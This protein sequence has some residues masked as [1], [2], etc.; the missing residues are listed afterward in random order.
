MTKIQIEP[1]WS[2]VKPSGFYVYNHYR[3]STGALAYIGKGHHNRAWDKA[4]RSDWW[5]SIAVKNGITVEIAQDGMSE[6]DAFA[7]EVKLIAEA[8]GRGENICNVTIGGEGAS[9]FAREETLR[10]YSSLGEEFRTA[11]EAVNWM[12]ENGYPKASQSAISKCCLNNECTGY[13]RAWSYDGKP[14][15]PEFRGIY[16]ADGTNSLKNLV[17]RMDHARIHASAWHRS[18][19]GKARHREIGFVAWEN[20]KPTEMRCDQCS[21]T[22]MSRNL[23]KIE[24]FCTNACKSA[25]RRDQKLDH[26]NKT[27]AA[28]GCTYFASKYARAPTCSRI[29][30]QNL[31]YGRT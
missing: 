16:R 12:R 14:D 10:V 3:T 22:F 27:C 28:C 26:I 4:N 20:F 24:R 7:L 21:S 2:E 23:N 1:R 29:C 31:R 5:K 30:G 13:D 11:Y 9:G 6:I 18:E 15:H 19:D 25:W 17:A 8:R